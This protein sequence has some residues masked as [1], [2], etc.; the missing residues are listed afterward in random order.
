MYPT[1]LLSASLTAS[2][3]IEISRALRM[4]ETKKNWAKLNPRTLPEQTVT[5]S[6]ISEA[7]VLQLINTLRLLQQTLIVILLQY[8]LLLFN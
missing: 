5:S 1:R 6:N 8:F 7:F 2:L 3:A 4:G